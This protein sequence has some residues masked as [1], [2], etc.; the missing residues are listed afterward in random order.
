MSENNL[1]EMNNIKDEIK[2]C[3][4]RKIEYYNKW[5]K[6]ENMLYSHEND[7]QNMCKKHKWILLKGYDYHKTTFECEYCGKIH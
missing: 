4:R 7:L 1:Q 5:R 3:R 6:Y 2:L